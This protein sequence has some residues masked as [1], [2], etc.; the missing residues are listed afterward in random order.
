MDI[1]NILIVDDSEVNCLL[2]T[3]ILSDFNLSV[4]SAN[5]GLEAV[6]ICRK[7]NIDMVLMDLN[8]P[9]MNGFEASLKIKIM[10][11]NLPIILQTSYSKDL[12][13][14]MS[15]LSMIDDVVQKPINAK[16][17]INKINKHSAIKLIDKFKKND[18]NETTT[19]S[20]TIKGAMHKPMIF[21]EFIDKIIK[22][23]RITL[24]SK[25]A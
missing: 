20:P 7:E 22:P 23:S 8:M 4:T 5:N 21:K 24:K 19:F 18:L 6:N 1:K 2:I 17:L 15:F 9:V 3:E 16:E 25:F 11:P 14:D 13:K 10:K 12:Y